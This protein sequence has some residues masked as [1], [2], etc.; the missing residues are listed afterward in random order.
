MS[1]SLCGETIFRLIKE[2]G[3][4]EM[5]ILFV[6]GFAGHLFMLFTGL[7]R[8]AAYHSRTFQTMASQEEKMIRKIRLKR[9]WRITWILFGL[10]VYAAMNLY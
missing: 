6:I 10:Y 3:K 9:H 2:K 4:K 7:I 5:I 1:R 8:S